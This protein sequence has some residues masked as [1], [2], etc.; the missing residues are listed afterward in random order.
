MEGLVGLKARLMLSVGEIEVGTS[1][2][3]F[4]E[5]CQPGAEA[6]DELFADIKG[7]EKDCVYLLEGGADGVDYTYTG[8]LRCHKISPSR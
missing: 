4:A 6:D 7:S 5:E 3:S 1:S 8:F 2:A